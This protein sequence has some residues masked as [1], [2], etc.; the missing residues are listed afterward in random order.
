MDNISV[1]RYGRNGR[2]ELIL[3][4]DIGG[5]EEQQD[6]AYAYWDDSLVFAIVC[7]GMGGAE[8][9]ELA[10]RTAANDMQRL[11]HSFLVQEPRGGI[12]PFLKDSMVKLDLQV[13]RI[14]GTH[15]GGTTAVAAFLED[16]KLYWFSVGD[17]RLYIFRDG[18][19]VQ[20]T[21]DHNYFLRLNEQLEKGE[22]TQACYTRESD[23]GEALISFMGVGGLPVFDL[24][25]TPLDVM[26]GDILLLTTDGLYKAIPQELIRHILRG[27]EPISV[28]ADKLMRQ[29]AVLKDSVVLDNTTFALIRINPRGAVH[30]KG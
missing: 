1:E 9:G 3:R 20:A 30:E 25:N 5:R 22:I 27:R 16:D 23:R 12:V 13:S 21:R 15:R 14:L 18:E 17:S 7:D 29:I 2:Y 11:L 10:S 4:T 24:T 8:N 28:K 26:E 19:L 6:S